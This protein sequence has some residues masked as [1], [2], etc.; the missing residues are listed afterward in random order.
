[1]QQVRR[2]F[3]SSCQAY[4]HILK[5]QQYRISHQYCYS[6]NKCF[7]R[8]TKHAANKNTTSL[9]ALNTPPPFQQWAVLYYTGSVTQNQPCQPHQTTPSEAKH[10]TA[11]QNTA[12]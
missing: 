9:L 5:V 6:S 3:I 8:S 1:M 11:K 7:Q 10:S 2:S 12:K 4:V